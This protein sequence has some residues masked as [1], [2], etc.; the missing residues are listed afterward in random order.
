MFRHFSAHIYGK[1]QVYSTD[2]SFHAQPQAPVNCCAS[3]PS[4]CTVFQAQ[5]VILHQEDPLRAVHRL[6]HCVPVLI[7]MQNTV[8]QHT[9]FNLLQERCLIQ[10]PIK[11]Q[12]FLN[13]NQS[14]TEM[15]N[16][17]LQNYQAEKKSEVPEVCMP[18]VFYAL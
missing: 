2:L 8:F 10:D 5:K 4:R 15:Q 18:V 9:G 7:K 14:T 16:R 1:T 6:I 17:K 12:L 3:I 13:H 11:E